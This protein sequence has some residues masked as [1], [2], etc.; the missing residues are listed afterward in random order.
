[1]ERNRRIAKAYARKH[2]L[3]VNGSEDE[4]LNGTTLG[5]NSFDNPDMDSKTRHIKQYIGQVSLFGFK[6][7]LSLSWWWQIKDLVFW[8]VVDTFVLASVGQPTTSQQSSG[9]ETD[10]QTL[11]CLSD[12]FAT[13]EKDSFDGHTGAICEQ[14]EAAILTN[15]S[16]VCLLQGLR[17]KITKGGDILVKR[18]S[19]AN[20]FVH[21]PAKVRK[22]KPAKLDEQADGYAKSCSNSSS[23]PYASEFGSG[24][25]CGGFY[26]VAR[27]PQ[28]NSARYLL[29][30]SDGFRSSN[31]RASSL[32]RRQQ[33]QTCEKRLAT[34]S[35]LAGN[36]KSICLEQN[37]VVKIFDMIKFKRMLERESKQARPN[38]SHL[39]SQCISVISF[40]MDDKKL[41]NLPSWIMIIN[42]VALDLFRE[43]LGGFGSASADLPPLMSMQLVESYSAIGDDHADDDDDDD[44]DYDD[45]MND[46]GLEE[47]A[48]HFLQEG[49]SSFSAS[50]RAFARAAAEGAY[51]DLNINKEAEEANNPVAVGH[52]SDR[53]DQK[54][55]K[56]RENDN[57]QQRNRFISGGRMLLASKSSESEAAAAASTVAT[58]TTQQSSS[59]SGF[60]SHC[61][62]QHDSSAASSNSNIAAGSNS[63]TG[64]SKLD[65]AAA[66]P[67]PSVSQPVKDLENGKGAPLSAEPMTGRQASRGKRPAKLPHRLN[68]GG[69]PAV[70]S[71]PIEIPVPPSEPAAATKANLILVSPT[72]LSPPKSCL[73]PL[74]FKTIK[75]ID[76]HGKCKIL[77]DRHRQQAAAAAERPQVPQRPARAAATKQVMPA[78]IPAHA[79]LAPPAT[80]RHILR[81][82]MSVNQG[83][84][85]VEPKPMPIDPIYDVGQQMAGWQ[86]PPARPARPLGGNRQRPLPILPDQSYRAKQQQQQQQRQ[87]DE[88][89]YY[90]GLQARISS[91][92][93]VS[94][95]RLMIQAPQKQ[96]PKEFRPTM[97]LNF[98][99][100]LAAPPAAGLPLT[101]QSATYRLSGSTSNML[102]HRSED[103]FRSSFALGDAKENRKQLQNKS[104][105][106][107][108]LAKLFKAS[109][110]HPQGSGQ[111]NEIDLRGRLSP[112]TR[113]KFTSADNLLLNHHRQQQQK[114]TSSMW[115]QLGLAINSS[116]RSKMSR[117][118]SKSST[119]IDA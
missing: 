14:T 50:K 105:F 91:I 11:I 19:D 49:A 62:S 22:G 108:P 93:R 95:Q 84:R 35:P 38:R 83:G 8:S 39:Q 86:V 55:M 7:C 72:G 31:P 13:T 66:A 63:P 76:E 42:I 45:D 82:L 37:K 46:N 4:Y 113:S 90:S 101:K 27:P 88:G 24:G 67:T 15:L 10:R 2:Q 44:D 87:I 99:G 75:H 102:A 97:Q 111:A 70:V 89:L 69:L 54:F 104:S 12:L 80:Q 60:N 9:T 21:R 57:I 110:N 29:S 23:D 33:Q 59:S 78:G 30:G 73:S 119:K 61:S 107:R 68:S 109:S 25:G 117:K 65:V 115:T 106:A 58:S 74:E 79:Q 85:L 3:T 100:Q 94:N 32:A 92:N 116:F 81:Y 64:Q 52:Y 103:L 118:K 41:L 51:N 77:Y 56:W 98:G 48:P 114:Q 47:F 28:L 17:I 18:L 71:A 112:L 5:L 34:S 43:Q 53:A 40:V 26:G 20:V 16:S 36:Y 1:M 6:K 96:A